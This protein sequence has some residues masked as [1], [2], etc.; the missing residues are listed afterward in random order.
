HPAAAQ[1]CV[2]PNRTLYNAE[3]PDCF[4]RRFTPDGKYLVAFNRNLSGLLVFRVLTASASPHQLAN[5]TAAAAAATAAAAD[6]KSE[7]W[8]FFQLAWSQTFTAANESLHRDL[9][10]VTADNRYIIAVRL[11]RVDL[12]N[13]SANSLGRTPPA[14]PNTLTCIKALEDIT[15]LVIDIHSG[16]LVDSRE[17]LSD[18]IYL[19]GHNGVS[20]YEDRLCLL[21]LKHQCL[22]ILRIGADG[23]LTNLYDIGWNTRE[24]DA[25]PEHAL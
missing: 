7:F 15:V 16:R 4:F 13:A 10:L 18:I 14:P 5:T 23:R 11:R 21:S 17:Y 20:L 8:H 2:Y 9:C 1:A 6:G 22:R 3:T 24:D 25:A 12:A 19:S